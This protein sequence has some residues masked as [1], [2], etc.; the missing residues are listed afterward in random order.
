VTAAGDVEAVDDVPIGIEDIAGADGFLTARRDADGVHLIPVVP[1][2]GVGDEVLVAD[3]GGAYLVSLDASGD[4]DEF[5]LVYDVVPAVRGEAGPARFVPLGPDGAALAEPVDLTTPDAGAYS[6]SWR[7]GGWSV[8]V[9]PADENRLDLLL[10]DDAGAVESTIAVDAGCCDRIGSSVWTGT[11]IGVASTLNGTGVTLYRFDGDGVSLGEPTFLDLSDDGGLASSVAWT[12]GAYLVPYW[13]EVDPAE[14][15]LARV[16]GAD[17]VVE[18][19]RIGHG[20]PSNDQGQPDVAISDEGLAGV[21]WV[22]WVDPD[23]D[24]TFAVLSCPNA[25]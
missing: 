9:A 4:A 11:E 6:I 17:G 20:S 18:D 24:V 3:P 5:G 25:G 15:R 22:D 8:I 10:V 21:V 13:N 2:G 23:Y 19:D 16:S 7:P 1:G 14:I 12:R